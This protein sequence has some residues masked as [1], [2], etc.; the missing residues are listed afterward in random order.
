MPYE[1]LSE[2]SLVILGIMNLVVGMVAT[3]A[4][5]VSFHCNMAEKI[6]VS[7]MTKKRCT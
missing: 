2:L 1:I 5:F 4:N 7:S 3:V 6:D